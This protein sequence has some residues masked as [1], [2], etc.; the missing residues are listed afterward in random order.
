MHPNLGLLL[1][2][3][4]YLP[5][6]FDHQGEKYIPIW[7]D[8]FFGMYFPVLKPSVEARNTSQFGLIA[9]SGCIFLC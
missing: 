1:Y 5:V 7:L 9:V 4:A 2:R 6:F 8:R 3:D